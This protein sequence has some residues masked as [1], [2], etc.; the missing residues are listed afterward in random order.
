[1]FIGLGI[2][3]ALMN[4]TIGSAATTTILESIV[5]IGGTAFLIMQLTN[6][7]LAVESAIETFKF[8][9]EKTKTSLS[10]ISKT[11][12]EAKRMPH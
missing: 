3:L 5:I 9:I 1:M 11:A 7:F 8:G 12:S 6:G 4:S 2:G 10:D